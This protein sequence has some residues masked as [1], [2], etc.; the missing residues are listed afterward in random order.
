MNQV[1]HK[2]LWRSLSTFISIGFLNLS[3][4]I[5]HALA[6]PCVSSIA[7]SISPKVF[8]QNIDN[9]T[10]TVAPSTQVPMRLEFGE[11][12]YTMIVPNEDLSQPAYGG[13]LSFY[14]V[15]LAKM[16]EMT[17]D[18]CQQMQREYGMDAGSRT[19]YYIAEKDN[20]EIGNVNISCSLAYEVVE[21]YGLGKAEPTDVKNFVEFQGV[22]TE[23]R[24]IP[25]LD[26]TGSKVSQW[27]D[28]I[29]MFELNQ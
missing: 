27:K 21:T 14:D 7:L 4:I 10:P 29:S 15:H 9:P 16:F 13:Q 28:F 6:E 3:G 1:N 25:V 20:F 11:G 5:P 2:L 23:T 18:D 12:M 24:Y 8:A 19:W 17:Y 22:H 26:I